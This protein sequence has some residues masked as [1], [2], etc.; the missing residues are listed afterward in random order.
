MALRLLE[1]ALFFCAVQEVSGVCESLDSQKSLSLNSQERLR[2]LDRFVRSVIDFNG[3]AVGS[4]VSERPARHCLAPW[5]GKNTLR[6][7][8]QLRNRFVKH[9]SSCV[10]AVG[11]T[12]VSSIARQLSSQNK[13]WGHVADNVFPATRAEK[14]V[15]KAAVDWLRRTVNRVERSLKQQLDVPS[16]SRP[17]C[18]VREFNWLSGRE[19]DLPERPQLLVTSPPYAGA[20]DYTLAQR[21]SLYILG[22]DEAAIMKL[23]LSES[24]ARRKRFNKSHV[25]MWSHEVKMAVERQLAMMSAP[26]FAAFVMPHKDHGRDLGEVELKALM[27]SEGWSLEFEKH[28][29][30]RQVRARQSWTS[31]KRETILVFQSG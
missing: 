30:I 19:L 11:L 4:L 31:I 25:A 28:R 18:Y 26:A 27:S 7:I 9:P 22:A 5:Y 8:I 13:S 17:L 12:M 1:P 24:G 2:K 23:C 29:S 16:S 15:R 3:D 6:R 21:L 20:I 10:S 14:D